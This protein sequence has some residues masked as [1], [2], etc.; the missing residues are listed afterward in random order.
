MYPHPFQDVSDVRAWARRQGQELAR[1]QANDSPL[2]SIKTMSTD[3][4]GNENKVW[5][6]LLIAKQFTN[7]AS[8]HI[9]PNQRKHM[10][11]LRARGDKVGLVVGVRDTH[12]L[13]AVRLTPAIF[14]GE[15]NFSREADS[16]RAIAL[17]RN[18]RCELSR[19][20]EFIAR[21][22]GMWRQW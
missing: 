4:F 15:I 22:D 19:A 6:S 18:V 16:G 13:Y 3:Q 2:P 5:I 14:G 21:D 10:L 1:W 9:G 11:E 8:L 7:K 20:I 12:Q 17:D